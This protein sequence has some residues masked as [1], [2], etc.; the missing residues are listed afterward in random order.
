MNWPPWPT[1][2]GALLE[3]F[4]LWAAVTVTVEVLPAA[5][6]KLVPLIV[7]VTGNA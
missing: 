4:T 6:S 2:T 7:G 5:E 1:W 3:K